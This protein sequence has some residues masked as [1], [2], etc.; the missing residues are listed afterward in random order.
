MRLR[1]YCAAIARLLSACLLASTSSVMS[2]AIVDAPM[3][4]P[5]RSFTGEMLTDTW[6]RRPS[7][8]CLTVS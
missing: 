3:M 8:R 2:L 7:L 5:L 1:A 4:L 6:I